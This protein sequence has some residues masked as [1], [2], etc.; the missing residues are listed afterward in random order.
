M[1]AVSMSALYSLTCLIQMSLPVATIEVDQT[2]K[3]RTDPVS[4]G[5]KI[6]L[7]RGELTGLEHVFFR[8]RPEL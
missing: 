4:L 7:E 1:L 3:G 8:I 6:L 2:L 5:T